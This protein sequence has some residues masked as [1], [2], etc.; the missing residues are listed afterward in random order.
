MGFHALSNTRI[1][2]D[3]EKNNQKSKHEYMWK[4][5]FFSSWSLTL[6]LLVT[7]IVLSY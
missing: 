4:I 2:L 5:L 3:Y 7:A 6:A 1:W